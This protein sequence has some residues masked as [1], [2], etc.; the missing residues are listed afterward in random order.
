MRGRIQWGTEREQERETERPGSEVKRELQ[1]EYQRDRER[2]R[3]TEGSG[4][5]DGRMPDSRWVC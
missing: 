3:W 4:L 1:R 5:A 2:W